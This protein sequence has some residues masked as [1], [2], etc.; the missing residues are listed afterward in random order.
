MRKTTLMATVVGVLATG[1]SMAGPAQAHNIGNEGCTPGYWKN[2]TS[3]WEEYRVNKPV[4][5]VFDFSGTPNEVAA[6]ANITL[7]NALRLKG[8]ST[9]GGATEIL[10]RAAT[11][12]VLNAA[13]EGVGYPLRRGGEDGIKAQV[14]EALASGDR[15]AMLDLAA[16]LDRLNNLGCPL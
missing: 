14:N 11:A 12:S 3:N 16:S 1:L 10:L 5:E 8:G 6:Y 7:A 2:H 9:L 13:H 15:Q 4:G